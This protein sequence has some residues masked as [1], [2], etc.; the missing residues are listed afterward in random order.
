VKLVP[1]DALFV[2][3]DDICNKIIN[4]Y[5][6]P[7]EPFQ[8]PENYHRHAMEV[9]DQLFDNGKVMELSKPSPYDKIVKKEGLER[10][11]C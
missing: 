8:I 6:K 5:I 10:E 2:P 11:R 3:V 9:Q 7:Q 1:E 4:K